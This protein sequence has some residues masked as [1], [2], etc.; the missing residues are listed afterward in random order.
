MW[1]PLPSSARI[2][3]SFSRGFT[4][5]ELMIV[6][7]IIGILSAIAIPQYQIYTGRA[8]LAEAITLTAGLKAAVTEVYASGTA[9]AS[10]VG[11]AKGIPDDITANAG[12]FVDSLA[13]SGGV[14]VATM[15]LANVA[16]CVVGATVT[17]TP[18]VGS[19]SDVTI[20]WSCSTNASCKPQTC[21]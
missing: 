19:S 3:R 10:I 18:S 16:P 7:A 17:L 8:Q 9:F 11:G 5:V 13:V 2:A 6:V 12:Q 1:P 20:S 21:S 15:R 4:L 14:I